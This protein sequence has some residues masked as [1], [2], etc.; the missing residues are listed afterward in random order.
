VAVLVDVDAAVAVA[1]A[2][3]VDVDAAVAVAVLVDV[4]AAVAVAVAVNV[5]VTTVVGEDVAVGLVL[6]A[7]PAPLPFPPPV[8]VSEVVVTVSCV[9]ALGGGPDWAKAMVAPPAVERFRMR[10][11]T[12]AQAQIRPVVVR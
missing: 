8:V 6:D 11:N 9:A 4:D 12:V 5:L 7:F 2:V 3:L 1:V 10:A